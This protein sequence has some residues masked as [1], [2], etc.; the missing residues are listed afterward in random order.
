MAFKADTSFL[1]FLTMGAVGVR[2][3]IAHLR[4]QGFEAIELERYCASNKIWATKVKRLR[5]PD[6]LCARTGLRVEVRAK[7]DLKVRM[8]DAPNNPERRWDVGL[9]DDDAVAF[10]ACDGG[11]EQIRVCGPPVFFLVGDLRTSVNATKLGR[12]KSAAEGAERDREWR[13]TV[14][15]QDG[16]II[17][18]TKDRVVAQMA[19][20]RR[21]TYQLGD[22]AAYV[23]PGDRFLRC[24]SI[25]AG[26]VPRLAPLTAAKKKTW[27]PLPTLTAPDAVD[28]YAAAKAIPHRGL[29]A[30]KARA[31]LLAAMKREA[32]DRVALEIAASAARLGADAGA[33]HLVSVVSNH[34][35]G[36]LRMEAVLILTELGTAAAARELKRIATGAELAGNEL[37]QAAAWGLGKAGCRA[38]PDLVDLLGDQDDAVVLHAIAAFGA[39]TSTEVVASL[40]AVL[41]GGDPRTR[42]AASEALRLVGT[43]AVLRALVEAARA[44]DGQRAWVLA[45]L[46][47]L[48]AATVRT[49]LAGDAL[50]TEVEPMLTLG[51][52]ENW[53]AVAATASDLRFLLQQDVPA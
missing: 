40:V 37:R 10:V 26:V 19:S 32:D 41:R 42:A 51:P 27:D 22:K 48:D 43:G 50:L 5:L 36:D 29:G 21:Q 53:L 46:G 3:T 31:A 35:R 44:G 9:R 13:S 17:E 34:S 33:E 16:E 4:E 1:R 25:I 11:G 15:S 38:Y 6:I 28:R 12:P 14:P 45:T 24:A 7:S 52:T 39:D 2:A 47:R 49:A 30:A 18:V 23:R 20:G 8:S